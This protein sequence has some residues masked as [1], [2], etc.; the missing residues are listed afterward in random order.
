[1]SGAGRKATEASSFTRVAGAYGPYGVPG[2]HRH[3]PE[4][5]MVLARVSGRP[6][7]EVTPLF[8]ANLLPAADGI[9][10]TAFAEPADEEVTEADLFEALHDAYRDE[11]FVRVR[12]ADEA[13]PNVREVVGTNF[14]DLTVRLVRAGDDGPATVWAFAA[15]DNLVKGASGQ[16][17]QNMNAMFGKVE[18]LGL[19]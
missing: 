6:A 17:V 8:V 18:T 19:L 9:G 16:A 4:M 11:P 14:V 12:A 5:A 2:G 13:M 10:T 15:I 1:M 7:A 3:Q